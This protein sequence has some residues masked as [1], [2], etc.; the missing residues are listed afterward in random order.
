MPR[1]VLEALSV[2]DTLLVVQLPYPYNELTS[3]RNPSAGTAPYGR[4]LTA[5]CK[6]ADI[7]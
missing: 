6:L 5:T 4:G 1:N 2:N 3:H 7:Y